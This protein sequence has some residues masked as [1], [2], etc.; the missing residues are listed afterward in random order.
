MALTS[1]RLLNVC[2]LNKESVKPETC[3]SRDKPGDF[4]CG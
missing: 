4:T 3:A 2:F 1:A